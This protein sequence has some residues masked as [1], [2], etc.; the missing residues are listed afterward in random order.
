[1]QGRDVQ[2]S[3]LELAGILNVPRGS[4]AVVLRELDLTTRAFPAD[5]FHLAEAKG[6]AGWL[7]RRPHDPGNRARQGAPQ[8]PRHARILPCA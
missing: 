6:S 3:P 5:G 7:D 1:V 4:D 2:I 8:H